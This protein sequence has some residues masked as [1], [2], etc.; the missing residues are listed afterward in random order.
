MN[1]KKEED[2]EPTDVDDLDSAT[3][4]K[5]SEKKESVDKLRG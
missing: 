4:K 2:D 3:G 1:I 5:L